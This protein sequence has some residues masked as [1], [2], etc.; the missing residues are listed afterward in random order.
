MQIITPSAFLIYALECILDTS[1]ISWESYN[2]SS[3]LVSDRTHISFFFRT[4]SWKISKF[5]LG[6]TRSR[7]CGYNRS[8]LIVRSSFSVS[9]DSRAKIY[10]SCHCLG[11]YLHWMTLQQCL[12]IRQ[13]YFSF[14]LLFLFP[15]I[16]LLL[17]RICIPIKSICSSNF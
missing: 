15:A 5:I 13:S 7:F 2:D 10:S 14:L 3:I 17:Q 12:W 1:E 6:W 4:V 9:Q 16:I 11:W 8:W